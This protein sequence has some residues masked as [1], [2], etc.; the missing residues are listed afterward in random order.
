MDTLLC[1]SE[2]DVENLFFQQKSKGTHDK[3]NSHNNC[4]K[5]ESNHQH[6]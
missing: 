6:T 3:K 2:Y 5:F 4:F 1:D